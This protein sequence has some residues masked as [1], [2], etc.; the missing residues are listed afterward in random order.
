MKSSLGRRYFLKKA[1][2]G[3]LALPVMAALPT[4]GEEQKT[5]AAAHPRKKILSPKKP[6]VS[7]NARD[8]GATGDGATKDTVALQLLI[9]RCAVLGGG[10]A[11]LPAG[12]Y[13]TGAL[14]LRSN[15]KLR[16]EEGAS[17]LGSPDFA[18]YPFAEV[19]WEG[20]W[21]KGYSALISAMDSSDIGITG[22]G[23]II[24]SSAIL[25]RVEHKTGLR[26][27][28]LLE[29]TN[30]KDVAVENCYTKNYGM[31]S[32]HPVYCDNISF[33]KVTVESGADGID[34]DSCTHV[35]ID[36]CTFQTSDDCISLKSGRGE[37]GN[38][39]ARPTDD[40][41]ISNCTFSDLHFACIGIGSETSAG[42]R[43]VQVSHCKFLSA[44]TFAVYIKS[45]IE[46]GAF[47]ENIEMN[48]LDVSGAR[49]GFL[50]LNFLNSGKKDEF[51]VRG[52][53]GIPEVRNLRFTNVRVTD[54]PT[55]VQGTEI[56]PRKPLDGLTLS[57]ISGTCGKGIFLANVK[58]ADIRNI[59]VTGFAGSLLNINNVSGAGL[60]GAARISQQDLP[61]PPAPNA[62]PESAYQLH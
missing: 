43:N 26:L 56:D 55:L 61:K 12:N 33:N 15:V 16:V 29:F 57:N 28:A 18:D 14:T 60:E 34:V 44:N 49:Q 23:K 30:C 50:R 17:L 4:A 6:I 59:K 37:E 22:P 20:R 11:V 7:L 21:I 19:R 3:M 13:L 54:M 51:P 24:G 62:A 32:I 1:A 35:E 36:G 41:R 25:G 31:W 42:I 9:D 52:L 53:G 10:E 38:T 40:V 45:S 8:Y 48:D 46:R 2:Q 27:P 39:I 5:A 47:F 58:H